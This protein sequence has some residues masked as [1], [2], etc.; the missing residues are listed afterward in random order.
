MKN[1]NIFQLRNYEIFS[2]VDELKIIL[3]SGIKIEIEIKNEMKK[4]IQVER[5][6]LEKKRQE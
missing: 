4:L 2:S 3:E 1:C 6:N 5:E